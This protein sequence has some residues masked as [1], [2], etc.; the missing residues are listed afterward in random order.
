MII[1]VYDKISSNWNEELAENDWKLA[2]NEELAAREK[3]LEVSNYKQESDIPAIQLSVKINGRD[4]NGNNGIL[5]IN[6]S[7]DRHKS[8]SFCSYS[9]VFN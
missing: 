5:Q 1:Q 8:N 4:I 6:K 7:K 2:G 9:I 3:K